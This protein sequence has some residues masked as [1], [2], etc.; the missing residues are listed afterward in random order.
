MEFHSREYFHFTVRTLQSTKELFD[1]YVQKVIVGEVQ[2]FQL[3]GGW[4]D[5][6]GQGI[7]TVLCQVAAPQSKQTENKENGKT[8][9]LELIN[10]NIF[11]WLGKNA[12]RHLFEFWPEGLQFAVLQSTR[13]PYYSCIRQVVVT[14]VQLSE[15]G[16]ADDIRQGFT[17]G[18]SEI[19]CI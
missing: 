5:N 6:W 11:I 14:Q 4:A 2:Y 16:W 15:L 17:A 7:S 10:K 3:A 19:T 18:H 9:C 1:S 8:T 13:E 12:E